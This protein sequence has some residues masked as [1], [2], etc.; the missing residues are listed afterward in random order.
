MNSHLTA[1]VR[2]TASA[3]AQ[4]LARQGRLLGR[5]L[6]YGCGRG[7]DAY[8]YHMDSYDPHYAP[9]KPKYKYDTITCTYVLNTIEDIEERLDVLQKIQNLLED[10]GIAYI[11]VRNDI[12][13]LKGTTSKGTWQG[14]IQ[15]NLPAVHRDNTYVTYYMTKKHT[16]QQ[17]EGK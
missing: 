10:D 4:R 13:Q 16:P 7:S 12:K 14:H 9:Q 11:T 5:K 6:D 3:P 2:S 17:I 15:L 8:I 1:M